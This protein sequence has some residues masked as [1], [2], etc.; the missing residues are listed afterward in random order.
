MHAPVRESRV[1][2]TSESQYNRD[3]VADTTVIVA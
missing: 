1:H 3:G 2:T